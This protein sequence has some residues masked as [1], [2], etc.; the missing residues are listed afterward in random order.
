MP[1]YDDTYKIKFYMDIMILLGRLYDY[2]RKQSKG[3]NYG[4]DIISHKRYSTSCEAYD[5]N[6]PVGDIWGFI[7]CNLR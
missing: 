2:N 6:I 1:S 7:R 3:N 4:K 5:C